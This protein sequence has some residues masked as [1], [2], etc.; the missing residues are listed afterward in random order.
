MKDRITIIYIRNIAIVTGAR[1]K[2]GFQ[3]TL[4]LLRAGAI[5]IATT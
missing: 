1:I 4:K 5:V 3:T 2:I